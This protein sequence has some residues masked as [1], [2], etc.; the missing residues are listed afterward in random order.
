MFRRTR[1][2]AM[3]AAVLLA[4]SIPVPALASAEA[5]P[6]DGICDILERRL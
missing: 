1:I 3:L 5:I 4:V 6:W 2:L